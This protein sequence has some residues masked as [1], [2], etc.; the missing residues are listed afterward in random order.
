MHFI[1][2]TYSSPLPRPFSSY[3]F[4]TSPYLTY[5]TSV[6]TFPFSHLIEIELFGGFCLLCTLVFTVAL[7]LSAWNICVN[8][9]FHFF[10]VAVIVGFSLLLFLFTF[11]PLFPPLSRSLSPPFLPSFPPPPD[12][13]APNLFPH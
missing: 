4:L 5:L 9:I 10:H 13:P 7:S 6:L 1:C 8:A 3:P 11:P 2:I 12:H